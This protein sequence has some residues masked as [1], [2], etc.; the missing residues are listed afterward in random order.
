MDIGGGG[1]VIQYFIKKLKER[2]PDIQT[3][4]ITH[5]EVDYTHLLV[6]G[7]TYFS[8]E[9]LQWFK[10][11]GVTVILIP[12]FDRM[13]PVWLM[14]L[15]KPIARM[16]ILNIYS[17]RKKIF[18]S[19]HHLLVHNQSEFRDLHEIYDVPKDKMTI[20]HYGLADDFFE[21]AESVGADLFYNKYGWKD[22]V[23]CPASAINKRK[24]QIN[25][26]KA[27]AGTDIKLVLNNTHKIQDGLDEE[28]KALT[29][30]NPH[31]LLLE[32][33]SFD[34]LI[35]CYKNASVSISVSRAET[36]GLVNLE[37]AYLGC[38]LVV[39]DLEAL[40]EYLQ[41]HAIF[42]NQERPQ[43]ILRG[44]QQSLAAEYD[45]DIKQFILE[46]YRWDSY[47]DKFEKLMQS[48]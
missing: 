11:N 24:N 33:L 43:S 4:D 19:S 12:I 30:N 14:K 25:L 22:F 41:D 3:L 48:L 23:F 31:V 1:V 13:H 46:T 47:V 29:H 34:E 6:F 16:P 44:I 38:K 10:D 21:K 26:L 39:S 36:A 17:L 20:F 9:V 15:L 28:F 32:K 18:A 35:S 40:R 8:P 42:I 2:Y 27:I 37:A 45:P 5:K 7:C